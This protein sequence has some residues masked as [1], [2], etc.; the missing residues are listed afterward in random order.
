M[1]GWRRTFWVVFASNLISGIGLSSFLPY[2]PTLL[3]KLGMQD[4]H[5]RAVWSGILFGAAPR[6]A[7]PVRSLPS[8]CRSSGV[9]PRRAS[10]A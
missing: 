7:P 2:F 3:E 1:R 6:S 5:A 8:S 4:E 10:R 9:A